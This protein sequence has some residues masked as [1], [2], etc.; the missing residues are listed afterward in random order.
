MLDGGPMDLW[1][2]GSYML[3]RMEWNRMGV[4]YL[5]RCCTDLE[6]QSQVEARSGKCGVF[7]VRILTSEPQIVI[8]KGLAG[9]L[10]NHV[11][12][13]VIIPSSGAAQA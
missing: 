3:L 2:Y 10:L 9:Q 8:G 12:T 7:E 13:D 5:Q 4:T 11:A 6:M 1:I